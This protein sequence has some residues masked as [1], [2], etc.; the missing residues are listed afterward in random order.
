MAASTPD[1]LEPKTAR[2]WLEHHFAYFAR[3]ANDHNK[4]LV[5]QL[6]ARIDQAYGLRPVAAA[7]RQLGGDEPNLIYQPNFVAIE[8]RL[9][10]PGFRIVLRGPQD[11]YADIVPER[12]FAPGR[13]PSVRVEIADEDDLE[14]AWN[15]VRKAAELDEIPIVAIRMTEQELLGRITMTPGVCGGRPCI[16]GMRIRVADVLELLASGA[17]REEILRDYPYLEAADL[18]AALLFASRWMDHPILLAS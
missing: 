13:P 8:L 1:R 7:E 12:Q 5:A 16:R 4:D 18:D 11:R 3:I 2:D 10:K 14:I 17:P 6:V 15:A 9:D